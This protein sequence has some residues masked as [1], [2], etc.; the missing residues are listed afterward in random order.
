MSKVSETTLE[1][2]L[3]AIKGNFDFLKSKLHGN[4]LFLAV[5]KAFAYGSDSI[6]VSKYLE[7]IGVDYFAGCTQMLEAGADFLVKR[8]L[9][10]I[11]QFCDTLGLGQRARNLQP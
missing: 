5:V 10:E 4:T 2:N 9:A 8:P 11:P 1:I 3:G 6:V 7:K